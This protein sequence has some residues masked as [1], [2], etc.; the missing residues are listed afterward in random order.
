VSDAP[1]DYFD[2]ARVWAALGLVLAATLLIVG[3]FLDWVTIERLPEVVPA[4]QAERAEP[5]SGLDI[6]DGFVTGGAGI[7]IAISA[8]LLI[9]KAKSSYAWLA[10]A[11]AIVGGGIAISDYR[12]IDQIFEDVQGIGRGITPGAGL[13]MVAAG[14]LV[15]LV[16]AV[17]GIAATPKKG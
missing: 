7:V 2:N 14:A 11:A 17:A 13:T 12:G 16:S 15:G 5:F 1:R 8:A 6:G 9:L 3:S 4:D 10:F